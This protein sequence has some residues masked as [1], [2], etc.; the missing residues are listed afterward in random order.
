MALEKRGLTQND[1]I[2]SKQQSV[3]GY[4]NVA[5]DTTLDIGT[6]LITND[7]GLNW[8][9]RQE[10]DWISG[11]SHTTDDIVYH[12]GHIWKSLADT[13]TAEPGTDPLKWEDQ[14]VWSVNGILVEGLEISGNANVLTSGYVVENNLT[15]FE[16]ALRHQLFDRNIILK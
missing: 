3:Q 15:G 4:V 2:V 12:L 14:G 8:N 11:D 10:P 9:I 5:V 1:V 16:E 13:N 6:L 7:G